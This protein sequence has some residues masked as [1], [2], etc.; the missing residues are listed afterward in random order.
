MSGKQIK[1]IGANEIFFAQTTL[2]SKEEYMCANAPITRGITYAPNTLKEC[3][4]RFPNI[5]A[6]ANAIGVTS[7]NLWYS[8]E[9]K[10]FIP[11]S[12]PNSGN[13]FK[14]MDLLSG[15]TSSECDKVNAMMGSD[16]LGC[17]FGAPMS[18]FS[19]VCPDVGSNYDA[20]LKFRL[21]VA[22]FWGTDVKTPVYR[23]EFLDTIKYS[24]KLNIIIAGDR[25]IKPGF[26]VKLNI[27]NLS[28]YS[29]LAEDSLLNSN[30][31]LY[32]VLSVK[33]TITNSG[34]HETALNLISFLDS[35]ELFDN[36]E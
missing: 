33:N 17:L 7:E 25:S 16:W 11:V 21:T 23:A 15:V 5:K 12:D 26:I 8:P 20:Y 6:Y 32:Y 9:N 28:S 13:Q 1:T 31:G 35:G 27:K 29:S 18:S 30:N 19:C 3:F 34:V 14:I 4:N 2:S 24:K 10:N 22:S 36:I